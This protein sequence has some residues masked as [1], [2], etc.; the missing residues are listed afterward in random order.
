MEVDY[1]SNSTGGGE[2]P[3]LALDGMV[4][5]ISARS[6][7]KKLAQLGGNLTGSDSHHSPTKPQTNQHIDLDSGPS[8][9]N[10]G[11]TKESSISVSVRVRPFT[12]LEERNLIKVE[13]DNIFG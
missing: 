7:P 8:N 11:A 9:V 3:G 12:N 2:R 5:K 10:L 1:L 6:S 4:G 13:N